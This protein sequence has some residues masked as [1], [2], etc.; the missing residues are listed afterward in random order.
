[1]LKQLL[2]LLFVCTIY[3]IAAFALP[4]NDPLAQLH[5]NATTGAAAGYLPDKTCA[6]CH[7]SLYQSYQAVGMARSFRSTSTS[8]HI[9]RFGEEFFH[10]PSQRFY[11]ID[12]HDNTLIFSRY[13][14]DAQGSPINVFSHP[15]DWVLG[16]GNRAR[17]YLYQT[18]LGELFMLPIG[19]YSQTAEWGMSPGFEGK[20]HLG[21][22]RQI[23][24]ECLF[25]H[26]AFPQVEA[27]SDRHFLPDIFPKEL[28]LGTGCQRCHGPGAEHVRA[29]LKAESSTVVQSHI[30]NPKKLPP[31]ERD[32]ICFQ[33]HLL[34]NV[35][36]IG[37]RRFDRFDYD[38]RPGQKLTDY[39]VHVETTEADVAT[40]NIFEINH[41]GYRLWQSQCFQKSAGKL[42]CI[43]CH[44]PHQ[45][46]TSADFRQTVSTKCIECHQDARTLHQLPVSEASDCVACHMPTTRTR[47]VI[48]VTMTDHRIT[49]GPI[50]QD[51]LLKDINRTDPVITDVQVL[52]WGSPPT[53]ELAKIYRAV[54]V[55]RAIPTMD[56]SKAL[57]NLL[58]KSPQPSVVPYI[59]LLEA[60]I[61]LNQYTSAR[62]TAEYLLRQNIKDPTVLTRY[63]ILLIKQG[64]ALQAM[65]VLETALTLQQTPE[66][67]YNLGL[68]A[69]TLG[70]DD[71]ALAQFSLALSL[72]PNLHMAWL[73]KGR[74]QQ[75]RQHYT[76][77]LADM[78][79]ALEIA[80]DYT[81]AYLALIPLLRQQGLNA[82]AASYLD[83]GLRT[84]AQ[85]GELA[86]LRP[87]K[88][89]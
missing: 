54:S 86:V 72:R 29:A 60:E 20:T 23:K 61:K 35:G 2:R 43:T 48:K 83:V 78:R 8:E 25:C 31:E 81:P 22:Q 7:A 19:W 62:N 52:P 70:E 84:V 4:Q 40:E 13:Q 88:P 69:L 27:G 10:E 74:V 77:A 82:E 71:K 1:M 63:G 79:K 44:N 11:R 14:K 51:K 21:V 89:M 18:E 68:A 9:E 26:N 58:L 45:K 36:I 76:Q 12:K 80:P 73:Y 17:S 59:D 38:F 47:D 55:L 16:S 75:K 24:R 30:I 39:L 53:A 57:K 49:K 33:C 46:P 42:A 34:P 87:P 56:A 41:H 66:T 50:D 85:P 3:P 6:T 37:S 28:P 32:A 64:Q 15:I 5:V 65:R 67:H